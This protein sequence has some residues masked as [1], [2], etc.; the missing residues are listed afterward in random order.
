MGLMFHFS[1]K[2]GTS[3][4]ESSVPHRPVPSLSLEGCQL[5]GSS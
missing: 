1:F 5:L 4:V 2:G 3:H